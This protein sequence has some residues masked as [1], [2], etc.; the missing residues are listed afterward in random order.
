LYRKIVSVGELISLRITD[1]DV[2]C[3]LSDV[4]LQG[5]CLGAWT[6][7]HFKFLATLT[8]RILYIRLIHKD[9]YLR[10]MEGLT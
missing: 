1:L 7:L 10:T 3:I 5:V 6:R 9:H 8:H 2:F 4:T